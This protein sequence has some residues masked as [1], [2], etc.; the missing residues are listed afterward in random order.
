V[1]RASLPSDDF[2]A[3]LTSSQDLLR[4]YATSCVGNYNDACDVMQKVNL[5]LLKK[6]KNFTSESEFRA[7]AIEVAKYEILAYARSRQRD[8]LV[9]SPELVELMAESAASPLL[10][11]TD[12]H[13]ALRKCL[14]LLSPD[15]QRMLTLRYSQDMA[16]PE[17][18]VEFGKSQ[19]AV[20][21]VLLRLRRSL[22]K[23]I[24]KQLTSLPSH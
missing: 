4:A 24:A 10:R 15:K 17:L 16:I 11:L 18:S 8:R 5:V 1:S 2:V 6:G 12:R 23:C 3:F 13:R 7:W 9:F 19:G 20:K 22:N 14:S 21:A